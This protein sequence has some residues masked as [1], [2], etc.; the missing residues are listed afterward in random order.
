MSSRSSRRGT[1]RLQAL[2]AAGAVH[3]H[4]AAVVDPLFHDSAFFD[5]NDVLQVKYEMLRSVQVGARPVVEACAAFGFSRPVFYVAQT[6]F[7]RE[8]LPGLLPHKRGPK[9][10]HKLT[11]EV[12]EILAAAIREAGTMPRAEE[13]AL[14]LADRCAIEAHPRTIVRRLVPYL[15]RR[16]K[17]LP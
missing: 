16:E 13:L 12:L 15:Q 5:P 4:P 8:G 6:A 3:P 10:P 17:K 9:Q 14:L 11:N 1:Q 2:T 7:A